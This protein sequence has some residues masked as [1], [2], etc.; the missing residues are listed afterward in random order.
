MLMMLG[1]L[2]CEGRMV[3]MMMMM[4]MLACWEGR[5][6]LMMLVLWCWERLRVSAC[7]FG[8]R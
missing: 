4:M 8:T 2:C 3:M 6:M 5:M 7:V 1:F